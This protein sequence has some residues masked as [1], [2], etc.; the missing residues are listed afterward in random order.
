MDPRGS[1]EERVE[2]AS[3]NGAVASPRWPDVLVVVGL[4]LVAALAGALGFFHLAWRW[5]TAPVPVSPVVLAAIVWLLVRMAFQ[6]TRVLWTA[7]LPWAGCLG[8]VVFLYFA[9]NPG[10][11]LPLRVVTMDHQTN[12]AS[13]GDLRGVL[14]LGVLVLA[15][16][17]QLSLLWATSVSARVAR[18]TDPPLPAGLV[19]PS[20]PSDPAAVD[21]MPDGT[22]GDVTAPVR[23]VTPTT[24]GASGGGAPAAG[25]DTGS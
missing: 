20:G 22:P 11:S 9:D 8:V 19:D 6:L 24:S 21:G 10:F 23:H 4:T 1:S 12:K 13:D 18:Q 5:G 2:T 25:V 7:V 17:V 16:A 15:A 3:S 14:L